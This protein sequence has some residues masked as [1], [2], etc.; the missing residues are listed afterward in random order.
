MSREDLFGTN[1]FLPVALAVII[2]SIAPPF[3]F[4]EH[5]AAQGIKD[6]PAMA[7]DRLPEND[8]RME[9]PSGSV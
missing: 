3:R 1:D 9:K 8:L 6:S 7:E 5:A 2:F 4:T